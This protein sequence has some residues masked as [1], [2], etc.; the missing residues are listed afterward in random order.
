MDGDGNLDAVTVFL[1]GGTWYVFV[2][3]SYGYGTRAVVAPSGGFGPQATSVMNVGVPAELALVN[4]DFGLVGPVFGVWFLDECSLEQA[5]LDGVAPFQ[6]YKGIGLLH[7]EGFTCTPNGIALVNAA[8][9]G[10]DEDVWRV[11]ETSLLW[12]PGLGDFQSQGTLSYITNRDSALTAAA[13]T[14]C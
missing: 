3:L 9:P 4:T 2:E 8:Q 10:A 5:T 1:D 7:S 11:D 12:V 6:P 13:D 14:G